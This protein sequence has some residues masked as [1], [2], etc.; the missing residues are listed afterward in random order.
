[1]TISELLLLLTPTWPLLLALAAAFT[2]ARPLALRC[3]PWAA[4]P[5]LLTVILPDATLQL[6][7]VM[8]GASLQLDATG[9]VFLALTSL[10]WLASGLLA[11]QRV[12]TD[13]SHALAI[14][15]LLAM[16]GSFGMALAGDGLLFFA[17]ATL[18][19]YALYAAL[20]CGAGAATRQSGNVLVVLLVISDLLVFEVLLLLG[21][22]AEGFD[23]AALRDAFLAAESRSLLL[24]L[25]V[26]GFGIK[27]GLLGLHFWLPPVFVCSAAALRPALVAYMFVAGIL[28]GLRLLPVGEMGAPGVADALHLWAWVTLAYALLVGGQQGHY[29]SLLAYAAL[30]LGGLWLGSLGELL[31]RP[32]WWYE[33][34]PALAAAVIQSGFALVILLL[35]ATHI[36]GTYTFWHGY[37]IA[38]LRWLAVV[39]LALA[40]V[41]LGGLMSEGLVTLVYSVIAVLAF[42]AAGSAVR[43]AA[44]DREPWGTI[45]QPGT[46][47]VEQGDLD[48]I[49]VLKVS[50]GL[51]VAAALVALNQLLQLSW[52][53]LTPVVAIV[54]LPAGVAIASARLRAAYLPSLPPGDL[55]AVIR[56]AIAWL[57]RASMWLI[58]NTVARL[59]EAGK[60]L[61]GRLG[62]GISGLPL[63]RWESALNRWP[64]AITWV[65]LLGLLI[66][67]LGSL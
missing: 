40:P 22:G 25:L 12:R 2:A 4:L 23:F 64:G 49:A 61:A 31:Q 54:L 20:M 62:A 51:A 5:A 38:A 59:P 26:A 32:Q 60:A 58:D 19:G 67:W 50:L 35:L 37:R 41:S 39:L 9:R 46:A 53:Q 57:Q 65:L 34:A 48:L 21:Q 17:A 10:L 28:G 29:R 36:G 6:D 27:F 30:A 43:I 55:L 11:R 7:G 14:F 1:M 16:S 8:L 47:T 44:A 45:A 15:L 13:A 66:V 33:A 42:L 18:G 3:M 56:S 52:S 63:G 24:A